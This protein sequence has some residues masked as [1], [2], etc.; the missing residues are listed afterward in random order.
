MI[1]I[2]DGGSTKVDWAFVSAESDVRVRTS[3]IN[4]AQLD[5]SAIIGI[6]REH[7]SPVS[8]E[9]TEIYF[10][11]AGVV[12]EQMTSRLRGCFQQVWPSVVCQFYSDVLAS[13]VALFGR[14]RG[15]A[16]I[17]GTGSNSCLCD[18]AKI[19]RNIRAGGFILGDEGSGAWI[20]KSLL[21]DYI[22]EI[23]PEPLRSDFERE[24]GLS[25][26]VIVDRVYRQERPSAYLAE[27]NM[28]AATRME[29]PYIRNLVSR[30]FDAFLERNV[31]QYEECRSVPVGFVGSVAVQYSQILSSCLQRKGLTLKTILKAPIDKL[32]EYYMNIM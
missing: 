11:G 18:D 8:S 4:P 15:I 3:G 17:L 16:C 2:A 21:Q 26:P 14:G 10:Y 9:V 22:K 24:Y 20:G 1:L 32:V 12:G 31:M 28:F 23:M 7:L 29:N 5:D 13:A 25:Y 30:G 27:L 6:L 19:V